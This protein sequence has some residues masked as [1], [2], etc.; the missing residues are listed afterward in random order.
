MTLSVASYF[1]Y[2]RCSTLEL[3]LPPWSSLRDSVRRA[4]TLER[5]DLEASKKLEAYRA[6]LLPALLRE[7]LLFNV[8]L[9]PLNPVGISPF[10]VSFFF[11]YFPFFLFHLEAML[12]FFYHRHG[13]KRGSEVSPGSQDPQEKGCLNFGVG[14]E[15]QDRGDK[16]GRAC[17]DARCRRSPLRRRT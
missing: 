15:S 1:F 5:D 4:S 10:F 13:C 16:L 6:P 3:G 8:S 11:W 2:V 12:I 7:Q 17:S 14:E 9:S